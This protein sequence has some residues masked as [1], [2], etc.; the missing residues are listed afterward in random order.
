V[1][2][3][4]TIAP[5]TGILLR[6]RLILDRLLTATDDV[7]V[8]ELARM[9]GISVRTVRR[10]LPEIEGFLRPYRLSLQK[11]A[12][13]GLRLNGSAAQ[14]KALRHNLPS[15][16]IASVRPSDRQAWMACSLLAAADPVKLH[17]L[18]SELRITITTAGHDLDTLETWLASYHLTLQRRRGW[19]VALEG[20]EADR[21]NAII[22]LFF[23]QFDEPARLSLF[24]EHAHLAP[25]AGD[26][27]LRPAWLLISARHFRTTARVLHELEQA[28]LLALEPAARLEFALHVALMLERTGTGRIC[29]PAAA[30]PASPLLDALA[31]RLGAVLAAP[32]PAAERA[33]L[34]PLLQ[35]AAEPVVTDEPAVLPLLQ[36]FL[37]ACDTRFGAPLSADPVLFDGLLSH[38]TRTLQRLRNYLPIRNPLL[39]EI[40]ENYRELFT[41][42]RAATDQVFTDPALPDTEI[43]FLVLHIGSA[44]ERRRHRRW[45]TLVVCSAGV[46]T[47]HMLASRL[48]TELP[49]IE[50]V[51]LLPWQDAVAVDPVSYDLVL[52]TIPLDWPRE[53]Y[54]MVS[55]LLQEK[56]VREINAFL[57][58]LA[59]QARTSRSPLP[60]ADPVAA[61]LDHAQRQA[62]CIDALLHGWRIHSL[63]AHSGPLVALI[64]AICQPLVAN[65]TL[66]D[67]SVAA[68]Q[69]AAR[70]GQGSLVVPGSRLAFLH[71]RDA[72]VARPSITL[73]RLAQPLI[74]RG[75]AVD[76]CL[77]ML[78]PLKLHRAEVA[79]LSR[80]SSLL[81]EPA[82]IDA[83]A[84]G[85]ETATRDH[86]TGALRP[87][88]RD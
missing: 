64:P 10:D 20:T 81:M 16:S 21:R 5:I 78:A 60:G 51:R 70:A 66:L 23:S 40:R 88:S 84:H 54:L 59:E 63:P 7:T 28:R 47:S 76:Q 24:D 22:D 15:S 30:A 3:A 50:I 61:R 62:A 35:G 17:A 1:P 75:T 77:L 29:E 45:R 26:T 74:V 73:H 25:T 69:L 8:G 86:L 46:G 32:L 85:D 82:T 87:L 11:K 57:A 53:R 18:A 14:R 83:L 79:V 31:D 65:G 27:F 71:A 68:T 67:S 43:G 36:H 34:S 48:R 39:Q 38:L 13:T 80:I 41:Q 44:L 58:R 37:L 19:G 6:Q 72:G 42:V 33:R 49:E 9:V 4:T 2:A 52:S 55:P 56:D 12:G